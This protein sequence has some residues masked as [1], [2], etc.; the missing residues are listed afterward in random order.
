M[1]LPIAAPLRMPVIDELPPRWQEI[2]R[3]GGPSTG[4]PASST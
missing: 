3:N 2:T 4:E 1:L